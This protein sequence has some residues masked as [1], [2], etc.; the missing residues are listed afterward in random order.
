MGCAWQNLRALLLTALVLAP[1]LRVGAAEERKPVEPIAIFHG[2]APDGT[3][4][5]G[6]KRDLESA[7]L[8]QIRAHFVAL[9]TH[10]WWNGLVPIY[11]VQ[12]NDRFELR[13]RPPAGEEN[14]L[15]PRFF[16]LP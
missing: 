11:G 2:E 15:E 3:Q 8:A 7:K 16:A 13:R 5:I 14:L 10:E 12:R 4:R 1:C 9:P 6:D